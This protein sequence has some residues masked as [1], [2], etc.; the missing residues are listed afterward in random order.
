M[1]C[2]DAWKMV[3]FFVFLVRVCKAS[4]LILTQNATLH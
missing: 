1:R 3:V 4:E 2:S